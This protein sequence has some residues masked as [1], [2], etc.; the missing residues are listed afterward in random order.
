MEKKYQ[1]IYIWSFIII[2][3]VILLLMYTPLG[4]N[5]HSSTYGNDDFRGYTR[6]DFSSSF[7]NAPKTSKNYNSNRN[8]NI[9]NQNSDYS[10]LSRPIV[11]ST[12]SYTTRSN[13]NAYQNVHS[14]KSKNTA[15]SNGGGGAGGGMIALGARGS[16]SSAVSSSRGFSTG[17]GLFNSSTDGST[18]TMQKAGEDEFIIADPGGEEDLGDPLP[19]GDG[20]YLL[21]FFA[22]IYGFYKF[23]IKA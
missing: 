22:L 23:R 15:S 10:V 11:S 4:G 17:G 7:K 2:S 5:I 3:G 12:P 6:V 8:S 18:S 13:S 1:K 14:N 21:L 19:V 16:S 9:P 20:L